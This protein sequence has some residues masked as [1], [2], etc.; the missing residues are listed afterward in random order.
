MRGW[1]AGA[2]TLCTARTLSAQIHVVRATSPISTVQQR[3]L[4]FATGL[5]AIAGWLEMV[6]MQV[7]N[8]SFS[9]VRCITC[10]LTFH[11]ARNKQQRYKSYQHW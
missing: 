5:R 7:W 3:R 8:G 1:A 6:R 4:A 11:Y 10:K 2:G 9:S